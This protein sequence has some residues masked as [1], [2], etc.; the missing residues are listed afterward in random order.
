[1]TAEIGEVLVELVIDEVE[2]DE[3]VVVV[4]LGNDVVVELEVGIV[5]VVVVGD[6]DGDGDDVVVVVLT[7]VVLVD[8]VGVMTFSMGVATTVYA[9]APHRKVVYV[10]IPSTRTTATHSG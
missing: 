1:M 9:E 2:D 6:G 7:V 5:V 8:E 10:Y 4:E 3:K